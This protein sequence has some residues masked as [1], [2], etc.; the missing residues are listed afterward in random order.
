[1]L[2]IGFDDLDA[3][4][5][6]EIDADRVMM[7]PEHARRIWRFVRAHREHVELIVCHC[8]AGVS[9]SPAVAAA[10]CHALGG[11]AAP[12]FRDFMPNPHVHRLM[13]GAATEG[14]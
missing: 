10:V 8:E 5:R 6:Y 14:R 4:I 11:D 7:T 9:R 1:M 13:L 2:A 12:F 3:D